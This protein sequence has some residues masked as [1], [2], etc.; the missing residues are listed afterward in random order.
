MA[1]IPIDG[2]VSV[3]W[4]PAVAAPATGP[5]E[6]E[7]TAGT[8][9]E[10][11]IVKADG[12]D[13][14]PEQAMIPDTPLVAT[15]ETESPTGMTKIAPSLK[16]FKEATPYALF[17]SFAEGFL[18]IRPEVLAATAHAAGQKGQLYKLKAGRREVLYT[19]TNENTQFK[20]AF[21]NRG[22]FKDEVTIQA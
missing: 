5:T 18:F 7:I 3:W 19:A 2:Y 21:G 6:A 22:D 10:A 13:L 15:S 17:A 12:L 14:N 9:L 1:A 4:L 8:R 11:Y 16:F 20:V